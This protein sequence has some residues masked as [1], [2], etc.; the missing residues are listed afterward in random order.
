MPLIPALTPPKHS[1]PIPDEFLK[2]YWSNLDVRVHGHANE[3]LTLVGNMIQDWLNRGGCARPS[4]VVDGLGAILSLIMPEAEPK[5]LLEMGPLCSF[6]FLED[7]FLDGDMFAAGE[8]YSAER[9]G[10]DVKVLSRKYR[11]ILDQVKSKIFVELLE[12]DDAQNTYVQAY[13][14]WAKASTETENL[15]TEFESLEEYLN[16]RLD[17][18]AASCGWNVMPLLHDFKLSETDLSDL[19]CIDQL[20][21][22]MMILIN[23]YYSVEND[24]S[25]HTAL[26]KPGLP[27]SAAYVIMRTR[28]VSIGEAKNIIQEEFFKMEKSWVELRDKLMKECKPSSAQDFAKY[29]TCLQYFITGILV[30]S[31]NA[32]RYHPSPTDI[33]FYPKPEHRIV[34][35][36]RKSPQPHVNGTKRQRLEEGREGNGFQHPKEDGENPW[37]SKY[38]QV[39]DKTISEPIEYI[40]SLPS[41]KIRHLAIDALDLWYQVPAKSIEIIKE[42]IDML[43]SS[44]LIIDDIE[45]SSEL[46]RGQPSAHMIFGTPQSINSANYLFVKCIDEVRRLSHGAVAI[47]ADELRNLHVGQGSDLYWTFHGECPTELEYIQMVDGKTGG[48]FRMASRLMRDQATTNRDLEVEGLLTLI[49]RFFQIRDD[50][51]NLGSVDYAKAK[52]SLSDLDEGKYSFM[53]IHALNNNQENGRLKGLLTLR[54]RQ[55][56][57]SVEQKELIMK[58]MKQSRSMEYTYKVLE[59]LQS[60]IQKD[61]EDLEFSIPESRHGDNKNWMIRAIMARLRLGD[62][63][64]G[65]LKK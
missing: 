31:L 10:R 16:E 47:F 58:C 15:D 49:G 43:H 26:D 63:K 51:Q 53:L 25:S 41:K 50:Y 23:D 33:P 2:G 34:S 46:R 5:R 52:G 35:L 19:N 45:D 32:P 6:S 12:A 55:R 42:V 14:E 62:A 22:R 24:W 61:L 1:R 17:N 28:D 27:P 60:R 57:L 9:N 29:M 64:V 44:S 30:F 7:D 20:S 65:S 8:A 18:F 11:N 37:L 59:E 4:Y 39:S 13:E 38:Y 21:Y 48:L 56:A 40:K 54:A 3:E 36:P